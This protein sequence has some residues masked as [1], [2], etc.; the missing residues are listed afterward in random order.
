MLLLALVDLAFRFNPRKL[1]LLSLLSLLILRAA[2]HGFLHELK[3]K[4]NP[5]TAVPNGG[6]VKYSLA[7]RQDLRPLAG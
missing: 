7:I 1:R 6:H 4:R 5:Y 3:L 2:D